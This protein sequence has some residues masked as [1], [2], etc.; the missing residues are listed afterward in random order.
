MCVCDPPAASPSQR[1]HVTTPPFSSISSSVSFRLFDGRPAPG[2][3]GVVPVLPHKL[4]HRLALLALQNTRRL[5]AGADRP[6]HAGVELVRSSRFNHARLCSVSSW[7]CRYAHGTC[8]RNVL[9]GHNSALS[10]SYFH[11]SRVM[12]ARQF[13]D[14]YLR[15]LGLSAVIKGPGFRRV[16]Q[17][18]W[19]QRVH[20]PPCRTF[21]PPPLHARAQTWAG[22]VVPENGG[23]DGQRVA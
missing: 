2:Y 4:P 12:I 5:A 7:R 18:A 11:P 10:V 13:R 9:L 8:F 17:F 19:R 1:T 16:N 20:P 14:S 6:G 21:P 15:Q 3:G 23:S 22:G